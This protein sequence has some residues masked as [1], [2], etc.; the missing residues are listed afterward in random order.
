M[1]QK[2]E[3]SIVHKCYFCKY[4]YC[5]ACGEDASP[6]ANHFGSFSETNCGLNM[7]GENK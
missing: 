2:K 6:Q 7:Y 1:A 5:S 3:V 4:I